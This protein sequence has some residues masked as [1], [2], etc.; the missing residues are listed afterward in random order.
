MSLVLDGL[1][2]RF[3]TA[4]L[5]LGAHLGTKPASAR[6]PIVAA[7]LAYVTLL[8]T[9]WWALASLVPDQLV[10]RALGHPLRLQHVHDKV[11]G[12]AF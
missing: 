10:F 9:A 5:E 11:L 7:F 1:E 8:G 3:D 6:A 4:P 2:A 12:N